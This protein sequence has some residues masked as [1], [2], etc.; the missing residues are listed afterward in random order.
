ML[1]FAVYIY[2]PSRNLTMHESRANVFLS[3]AALASNCGFKCPSAEK[4]LLMRWRDSALSLIFFFFPSFF[5]IVYGI[6]FFSWA[7]KCAEEMVLLCVRR[8]HGSGE[9]ARIKTLFEES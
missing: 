5:K 8:T 7:L 2:T 4:G 1:N 3:S 9:I 6:R